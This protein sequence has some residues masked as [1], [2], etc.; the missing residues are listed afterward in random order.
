MRW[1]WQALKN[2][3]RSHHAL[4][5]RD[6]RLAKPLLKAPPTQAPDWGPESMVALRAF[7]GSPTGL[8]LMARGRSIQFRNA[9]AACAD[10]FHTS[11]SAGAAKGFGE[12]LDWL[13]SLSRSCSVTQ[14][15]SSE[16]MEQNDTQP[17]DGET[18]LRDA[19][20]P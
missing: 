17:L 9:T 15:S 1:L 20:S 6:S 2:L 5:G 16:D 19:M 12:C 18:A 11:H 3:S 10:V 13:E 8:V 4:T 7:L 14:A